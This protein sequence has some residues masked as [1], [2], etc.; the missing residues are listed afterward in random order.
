MVD[1]Q[2]LNAEGPPAE[3]EVKC[4]KAER[5][6][7][8]AKPF[9]SIIVDRS[10]DDEGQSSKIEARKAQAEPEEE[11][12]IPHKKPRIANSDEGEDVVSEGRKSNGVSA[13]SE[14]MPN[15]AGDLSAVRVKRKAVCQNQVAKDGA[16]KLMKRNSNSCSGGNAKHAGESAGCAVSNLFIN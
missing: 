6:N 7:A 1:D 8:K 5:R 4:S 16:Y 9:K 10:L 14:I 3:A 15:E 13:A 11:D 2:S 12:Q